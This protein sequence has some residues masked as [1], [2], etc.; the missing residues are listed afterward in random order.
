MCA[1]IQPFNTE[2]EDCLLYIVFLTNF[3][4]HANIFFPRIPVIIGL[5]CFPYFWSRLT[6]F[7]ML[8]GKHEKVKLD[9]IYTNVCKTDSN[10]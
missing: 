1:P 10:S 2:Q 7:I 8:A 9:V 6:A 4:C 3:L 5:H